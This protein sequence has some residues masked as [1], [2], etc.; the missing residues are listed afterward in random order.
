MPTLREGM[1]PNAVNQT[2]MQATVSNA[3]AATCEDGSGAGFGVRRTLA[4]C[5]FLAEK[6]GFLLLESV[7]TAVALGEKA[8]VQAVFAYRVTEVAQARPWRKPLEKRRE[9]DRNL[10]FG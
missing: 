6:R 5:P 4:D 1:A 7:R 9:P 8:R 3:P 10:C 2:T